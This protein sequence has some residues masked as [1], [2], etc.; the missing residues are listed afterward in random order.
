MK[1]TID[2]CGIPYQVVECEDY[3]TGDSVHFGEIDIKQ[4]KIQIAKDMS[5]EMKEQTLMHELLHGI[6]MTLGYTEENENEQFVTAVSA[7]M[8]PIFKVR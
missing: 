3:F 4:C 1:K 8:Y 5:K 7:A 6:L 2:I